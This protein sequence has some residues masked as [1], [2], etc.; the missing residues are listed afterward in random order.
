MS[1]QPSRQWQPFAFHSEAHRVRETSPGLRVHTDWTGNAAVS[2][3]CMPFCMQMWSA[4]VGS[5]EG[6]CSG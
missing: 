5:G 1:F 4:S 3:V 6:Q 2:A